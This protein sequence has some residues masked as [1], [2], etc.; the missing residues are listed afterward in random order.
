LA[1]DKLLAEK[2]GAVVQRELNYFFEK[3]MKR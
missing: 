2:G 3:E 1:L